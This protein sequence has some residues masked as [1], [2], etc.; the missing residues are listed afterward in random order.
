ML[1]HTRQNGRIRT[2]LIPMQTRKAHCRGFTRRLT[3]TLFY[4]YTV[5]CDYLPHFAIEHSTKR[6][7]GASSYKRTF[8]NSVILSVEYT[9]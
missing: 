1:E 3:N 6:T 4:S 9:D 7:S 2:S 5:L 8:T